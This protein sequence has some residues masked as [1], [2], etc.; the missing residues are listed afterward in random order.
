MNLEV[1]YMSGAGNLFSVIDNRSLNLSTIDGNKLA[2]ILCSENEINKLRTEGLMFLEKPSPGADFNCT[3]FNPDGSSGMM[4]GN[5][6]RAITRFAQLNG[7][8]ADPKNINFNMSG[9][10]YHSELSGLN[11]KLLMPAPKVLPE[12]KEIK[13]DEKKYT[14]YYS[15]TGTHHLCIDLKEHDIK[16]KELKIDK[17]GPKF[18]YHKSFEPEGTNVNFYKIKKD[19]VYLK[20]YEKGVEAETGACGTGA[21]S[22]ALTVNKINGIDFPIK[23]IPTSGEELIID[24]VVSTDNKIENMILEGPAKV[25]YQSNINL[26]DNT[27][28]N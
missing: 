22:T 20:T 8:I 13:I 5:G 4:C 15:N 17:L 16:R 11:I 14:A 26:P 10:L 25:I 21:V 28:F 2:P 18:R 6:G 19:V 24:R 9:D 27:F 23:I 7:M 1:T 12:I 3:F